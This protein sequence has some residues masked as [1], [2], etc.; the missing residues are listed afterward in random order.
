MKKNLIWISLE[1]ILTLLL[2]SLLFSG[3]LSNAKGNL[4]IKT[5]DTEINTEYEIQTTTMT[6]RKERK[7]VQE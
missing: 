7:N 6:L 3:C 5:N 2:L 1:S 4:H